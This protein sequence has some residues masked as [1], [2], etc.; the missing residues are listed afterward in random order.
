MM[1]KRGLDVAWRG[2]ACG[3]KS[4]LPEAHMLVCQA[5]QGFCN[6]LAVKTW[7]VLYAAASVDLLRNKNLKEQ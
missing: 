2:L 7:C 4:T 1:E 6:V 3:L 5:L